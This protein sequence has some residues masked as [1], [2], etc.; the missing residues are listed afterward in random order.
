[1]NTSNGLIRVWISKLKEAMTCDEDHGD[2]YVSLSDVGEVIK[3]MEKEVKVTDTKQVKEV[4]QYGHK[5][6][7]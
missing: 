6:Y 2:P 1:M 4:R 5:W 3:L 7:D